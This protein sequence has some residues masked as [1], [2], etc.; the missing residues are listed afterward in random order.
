MIT[1]F[2]TITGLLSLNLNVAANDN[3]TTKTYEANHFDSNKITLVQPGDYIL[4]VI[5]RFS[6]SSNC[7]S[8]RRTGVADSLT[9]KYAIDKINK[10]PNILPN[11]TLGYQ[12]DSSCASLPI[13]MA[14]GIETISLFRPDSVCRKDF[15][16]CSK[17]SGVT[18]AKENLISAVLATRMSFTTIPLA[19]L[20]GLY[21][22]PQISPS[23]SSRLLSKGFKSFFRTIPSDSNQAKVMVDIL[24]HFNWTY[25]FAVGSDDD[26]GKLSI[27]DIKS[28]AQSRNICIPHEEYI[29]RSEKSTQKR[30]QRIRDI[31]LKINRT[32]KAEVVILFLYSSDG[33][34]ILQEADRLNVRRIWLTSEAWNPYALDLNAS[35]AQKESIIT[36]S[37]KDADLTNLREYIKKQV[38]KD[39]KCDVWLHRYIEQEFKCKVESSKNDS[40]RGR[41]CSDKN[42]TSCNV[43]VSDVWGKIMNPLSRSQDRVVDAVYTAAHGLHQAMC[44]GRN[45]CL[46]AKELDPKN[47][48][49]TIRNISFVNEQNISVSFDEYGDPQNPYYTVES[50]QFLDGEY[51]YVTVGHW[52]GME[53]NASSR[54][55]MN[56]DKMKWPYN[57]TEQPKSVC[58]EP[59][60]KG[61]HY[62]ARTGCCWNCKRCNHNMYSNKSMS[63]ECH[64]CPEGEHTADNINCVKTKQLFMNI[65]NPAGISVVFVS[66]AGI[67]LTL[68]SA[69]LLFQLRD[70][71]VVQESMPALLSTA[72]VIILAMFIY[73]PILV[74]KPTQYYCHANNIYFFGLFT[75]FASLLL[76]KTHSMTMFLM[77]KVVPKVHLSLF[78]AQI[79]CIFAFFTLEL[80]V[81][82]AWFFFH[83]VKVEEFVF[84]G[85]FDKWLMC[86]A[87]LT[88][89]RIVIAIPLPAIL[90]LV[91]TIHAFQERMLEISLQESKQK[92]NKFLNFTCIAVCLVTLAFL[93]TY[94]YVLSF[95]RAIVLVFAFDLFAF[96][97]LG[98]LVFPR[99]YTAVIHAHDSNQSVADISSQVDDA[100][101]SI[102]VQGIKRSSSLSSSP[103]EMKLI[104][105]SVGASSTAE[106]VPDFKHQTPH[107]PVMSKRHHVGPEGIALNEVSDGEVS[108]STVA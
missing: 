80:I 75:A 67:L 29:S 28:G 50:L 104:R 12:M 16:E 52:D 97:Y 15:Q 87:D 13:T 53:K 55:T 33:E 21:N 106:S 101:H 31:V 10:D 82:V 85:E 4:Q 25:V 11:I 84:P 20:L 43:P 95:Y 36:V 14:R 83:P 92:S 19:S 59:C 88:S 63:K 90:L 1:A 38:R 68:F 65:E 56:I 79:L 32:S 3:C 107:N 51:K 42:C 7:A 108:K 64:R 17:V 74:I 41:R 98:C 69:A 45:R 76:V 58:H 81:L 93:P 61:T 46:P 24:A 100:G 47:L 30:L 39:Y 70:S 66:V 96:I 105:K 23:A 18:D 5:F 2:L 60:P 44:Q 6:Q 71:R 62:F 72:I 9:I 99:V 73:G 102:S 57:W 27:A 77:K 22:V 91:A 49:E 26:Y 48:T 35:K 8:V 89:S 94:K 40:F 37:L 86:N 103:S 78:G 54:L 34:L